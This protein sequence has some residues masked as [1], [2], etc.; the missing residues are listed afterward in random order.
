MDELIKR[1][2]LVELRRADYHEAYYDGERDAVFPMDKEF[3]GIRIHNDEIWMPRLEQPPFVL[4]QQ[5]VFQHELEARQRDLVYS[6]FRPITDRVNEMA[7]AWSN[8]LSMKEQD[9]E[10]FRLLSEH[11]KIVLAARDDGVYGLHFVTWEY[12]YDRRSVGLGHYTTDYEAAKRDFAVRSGL[13]PENLMFAKEELTQIY[14]A[15][16]FQ[17]QSDDELT[18]DKEQQLREIIGKLETICPDLKE[19]QAPQE[20]EPVQEPEP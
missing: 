8:A 11:G 15:L 12:G 4:G 19:L 16:I 6:V 14:S 10:E 3:P 18:F 17:G 7:Y 1:Q 9:V 20:P 13:I 5:A 2:L